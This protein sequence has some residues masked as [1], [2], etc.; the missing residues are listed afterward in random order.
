MSYEPVDAVTNRYYAKIGSFSRLIAFHR[1]SDFRYV[2]TD[3]LGGTIKV[4]NDNGSSEIGSKRYHSFGGERASCGSV[5]MNK[6]CGGQAL[7]ASEGC[8]AGRGAG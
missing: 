4:V 6:P 1:G 3:H 5:D 7:D 8:V 2:C